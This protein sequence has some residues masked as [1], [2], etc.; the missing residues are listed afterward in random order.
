MGSYDYDQKC[1][2]CLE[3]YSY[4]NI[5]EYDWNNQCVPEGYFFDKESSSLE[6]CN[7]DNSKF[8]IDKKNGK[9]ICI[10]LNYE[11]PYNY[12]NYN[13][14]SKECSLTPKIDIITTETLFKIKIMYIIY[15]IILVKH[16]MKMGMKRYIIA[17][18][19]NRIFL[20]C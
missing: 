7:A 4:Y 19:A 8:Y 11:C 13:S 20:L 16:V 3:N 2:T 14:T 6:K 9:K 12:S 10:K 1:L 17:K 5:Y 18:N 15:V